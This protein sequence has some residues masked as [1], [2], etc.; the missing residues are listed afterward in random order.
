MDHRL[1]GSF[2]FLPSRCRTGRRSSDV[3][4]SIT[5]EPEEIK[6]YAEVNGLRMY[7]EVH[8]EGH[9]VVLLHGGLHSI[10]LS[11][12]GLLPSLAQDFRII[13]IDLQ[14]HGRTEDI[15]RPPLLEHLAA[16]VLALLDGLGVDRADFFGYSLGGL[17][18]LTLAT[19]YPDRVRR[20][21]LA[22]TH[23]RQDGYHDEIVK[24]DQE[25]GRLPTPEEFESWHAAYAKVA[26]DPDHF[27]AFAERLSGV[28]HSFRDWTEDELRAITA[29]ALIVVG[30]NDFVRVDHAEEMRDLLPDSR[31]AVLPGT[32]HSEVMERADLVL[33]MVRAFLR[34]P[35]A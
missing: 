4:V 15:D 1:R 16:D 6:M 34:S 11:F 23:F 7:Y 30:D 18:S 19:H 27:W 20:M 31:L 17:V 29:P 12:G 14:G 9:P 22:A 8:G 26:P 24:G 25:S 33:P 21:V 32:R 28:V 10:D 5:D 2:K 3:E 13:A 35:R